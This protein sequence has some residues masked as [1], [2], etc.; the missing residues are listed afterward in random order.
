MILSC[1]GWI[2]SFLFSVCAI[3]QSWK[4]YKDK[5]AHGISWTFLALWFFG[6]ILTFIYVLF[7]IHSLPLLLNYVISMLGLL[8][9]IYF[10]IVG[11]IKKPEFK[12][13]YLC[14][15]PKGCGKRQNHMCDLLEPCERY[16]PYKGE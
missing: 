14:A 4:C 3:P 12:G 15:Y 16:I 13:A 2:G 8:C 7:T 5:N 1:C 10:K 11:E 6:E 9:I